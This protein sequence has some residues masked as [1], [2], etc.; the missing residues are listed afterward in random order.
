[1]HDW[2]TLWIC[3]VWKTIF[4]VLA[5]TKF[6]TKITKNE[7]SSKE[8]HNK[9]MVIPSFFQQLHYERLIRIKGQYFGNI[10]ILWRFIWHCTFVISFFHWNVK[11][12]LH[13]IRAIYKVF[14]RQK[15]KE[16]PKFFPI[17]Y[18]FIEVYS[19]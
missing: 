2:L 15:V 8:T 7:T 4:P 9:V 5:K 14:K 19:Q 6:H 13:A 3:L 16:K 11:D 12:T 1:M 17:N 18:S 10:V